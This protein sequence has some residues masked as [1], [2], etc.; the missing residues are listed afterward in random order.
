[1]SELPLLKRK[2][3][4]EIEQLQKENAELK[5]YCI[6]LENKMMDVACADTKTKAGIIASEVIDKPKSAC[7][8]EHDARVVEE[9]IAIG[10]IEGLKQYINNLRE[11]A[12]E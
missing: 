11:E 3:D 6:A 2:C 1:M 4:E 8:A 9:C 12:R 7:L 10:S 5:A